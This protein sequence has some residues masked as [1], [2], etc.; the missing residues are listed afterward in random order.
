[1]KVGNA[2]RHKRKGWIGIILEISEK[3]PGVLVD[4]SDESGIMVRT[5]NR[6]ELEVIG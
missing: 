2:V 6:N 5:M 4:I 3:T 1:M